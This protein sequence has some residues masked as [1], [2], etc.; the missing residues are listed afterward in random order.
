[1]V[2]VSGVITFAGAPCPAAG[3]ITFSPL[4]VESGLPRRPGSATFDKDGK[5][6]VTSFHQGDGLIAGRYKVSITCYSGL[7][8][9]TKADPWGDV[10]YVPNDFQPPELAV[11]RDSKPIELTYDVPAKRKK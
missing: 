3:N 1:M 10:S 9:P 6:I 5:F 7:P 11:T 8:D 2:P 4:E